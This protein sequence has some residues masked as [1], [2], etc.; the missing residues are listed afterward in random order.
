MRRPRHSELYTATAG[1]HAATEQLVERA[2]YFSSPARYADY[3]RRMHLFYR[4]FTTCAAPY[5]LNQVAA[6]RIPG[7]IAALEADLAVLDVAPAPIHAASGMRLAATFGAHAP[8]SLLGGLYVL[9]G[10]TLGAPILLR[11][12]NQLD[13]PSGGGRAYLTA[14]AAERSWPRFLERLEAE[15]AQSRPFLVAGSIATFECLLDH[16]SGAVL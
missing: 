12:T 16:L 7:R 14:V 6:W 10:S 5:G 8:A 2:G 11:R 3:L 4:R 13:L 9:I 1:I 15:P